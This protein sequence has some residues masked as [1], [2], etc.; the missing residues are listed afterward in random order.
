MSKEELKK[1]LST[2]QDLKQT[3]ESKRQTKNDK[4]IKTIINENVYSGIQAKT[5]FV[6]W[7]KVEL[8]NEKN[9][10]RNQYRNR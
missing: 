1:A 8:K 9:L 4:I 7:K 10:S 5:Q 3:V 2:V 6:F